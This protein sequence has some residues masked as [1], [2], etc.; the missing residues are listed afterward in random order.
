MGEGNAHFNIS[1]AHENIGD[2]TNA[3]THME[4]AHSVHTDGHAYVLEAEQE[5]DRLEYLNY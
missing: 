1:Q 5:V 3:L 2:V 4:Q